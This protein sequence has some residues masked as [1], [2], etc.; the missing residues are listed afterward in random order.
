MNFDSQETIPIV[1]AAVEFDSRAFLSNKPLLYYRRVY[2]A[3]ST[4]TEILI[5]SPNSAISFYFH[6]SL[7]AE[8]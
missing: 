3:H 1:C 8:T 4:S 5:Y 6:F 7:S 2:N